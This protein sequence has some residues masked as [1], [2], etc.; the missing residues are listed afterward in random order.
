MIVKIHN[1]VFSE[2]SKCNFRVLECHD[3]KYARAYLA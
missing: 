3:P 1:I 2:G